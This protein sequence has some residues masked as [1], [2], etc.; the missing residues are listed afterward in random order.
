MAFAKITG[1]RLFARLNRTIHGKTLIARGKRLTFDF[2]HATVSDLTW[3]KRQYRKIFGRKLDLSHP[4]TFADKVLYLKLFYKNPLLHVC[5]DKHFSYEYVRALGME[6]LLIPELALYDSG[7][8]IDFSSLPDKCVIK[9]TQGSGDNI[10]LDK[11]AP[12]Y[13]ERAVVRYLNELV[14]LDYYKVGREYGYKGVRGKL[15]VQP[16]LQNPDGSPL[17]DYKFYCFDGV[18]RYYMVS[19]GEFNGHAVNH[20]FAPDDHSVDALFKER[21]TV[22]ESAVVLPPNLSQMKAIAQRLAAPFPHARV[23]LYSVGGKIYFGEMTFYSSGGFIHI[24]DPAA[25][26]AIA[27]WIPLEKYAGDMVFTRA[28]EKYKLALQTKTTPVPLPK[29]NAPATAPIAPARE[30][31]PEAAAKEQTRGGAFGQ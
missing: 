19:Y 13:S 4:E 14:K 23:D 21:P 9:K 5:A 3:Q 17:I 6:D 12:D 24:F 25:D 10:I 29:V 28:T 26:R 31:L 27:S 20:K 11:N 7:S 15:Q 1:S 8:D 22:P 16:F 30:I 18:L 2:L